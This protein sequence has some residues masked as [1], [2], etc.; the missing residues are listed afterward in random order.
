MRVNCKH[1]KWRVTGL[2][3]A[4][5]KTESMVTIYCLESPLIHRGYGRDRCLIITCFVY[6]RIQMLHI[7]T[8]QLF[9]WGPCTSVVF[10]NISRHHASVRGNFMISTWGHPWRIA[11]FTCCYKTYDAV[12]IHRESKSVCRSP[13]F[14][15]QV[16]WIGLLSQFYW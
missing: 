11:D 12:P 15:R 9:L 13:P 2:A 5:R 10:S 1:R 3:R 6:K 8:D 16:C 7:L 14:Q 4:W